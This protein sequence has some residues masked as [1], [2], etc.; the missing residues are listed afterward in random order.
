[1]DVFVPDES[2]RG[3]RIAWLLGRAI[4]TFEGVENAAEWLQT[5]NVSLGGLTPL[6]YADTEAGAREV[7]NLLGRIEY[8][9]YS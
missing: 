5:P 9:I 2:E 6:E 8:G 3:L 7:E 4:L 1:M